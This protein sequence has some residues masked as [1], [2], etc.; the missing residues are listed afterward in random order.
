VDLELP[1]KGLQLYCKVGD[2]IS[3]GKIIG[4]YN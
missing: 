2:K 1:E 4:K 3:R